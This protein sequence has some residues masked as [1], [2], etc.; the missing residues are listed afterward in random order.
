MIVGFLKEN[1]SSI[2]PRKLSRWVDYLLALDLICVDDDDDGDGCA[3]DGGS[4]DED[5]S[6]GDDAGDGSGEGAGDGD[7]GDGGDAGCGN[8]FTHT[9][10]SFFPCEEM[11]LLI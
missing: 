6:D 10:C 7:G 4:D 5:G 3:R 11:C 8:D 9:T 2:W 1:Q